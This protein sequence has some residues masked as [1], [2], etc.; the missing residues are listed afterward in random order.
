MSPRGIP[1]DP[2]GGTIRGPRAI[3]GIDPVPPNK[4]PRCLSTRILRPRVVRDDE[5]WCNCY[6]CGHEWAVNKKRVRKGDKPS[7]NPKTKDVEEETE[8]GDELRAHVTWDQ[9]RA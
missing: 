1:M 3:A 9:A 6:G 8:T 4:C 2:R 7:W 5:E